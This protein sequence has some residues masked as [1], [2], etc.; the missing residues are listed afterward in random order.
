MEEIRNEIIPFVAKET[1]ISIPTINKVKEFVSISMR[2]KYNA[3]VESGRYCIDAKSI[4]G[5]F[6]LDVSK[7]LNLIIE[8]PAGEEEIA[9]DF[10]ESI[11][12]FITNE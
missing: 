10:L 2:Y 5:L 6:S 9:N 1:T 7:P 4:M 12:D 11:K 3:S 8:Y